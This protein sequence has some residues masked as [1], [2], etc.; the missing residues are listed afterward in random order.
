MI[1]HKDNTVLYILFFLLAV[2]ITTPYASASDSSC[3]SCHENVR[4]SLIDEDC[5][6]CHIDDVADGKHTD[7]IGH[8]QN[9]HEDF[10]WEND[11]EVESEVDRKSESCSVCHRSSNVGDFNVCEN[12]HL[13]DESDLFRGPSSGLITL[14]SG[15][16]ETIVRVYAHTNF[17]SIY[18]PDQ[19]DLGFTKSTC[20]GFSLITGEGTCHGVQYQ[21]KENAGGYFAHNMSNSGSIKR[22]N[23]YMETNTIDHLP[24]TSD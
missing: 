11:N 17:S 5:L 24:D 14:R 16:N 2:L 15:I 22:S 23:P 1:S 19:S 4:H 8:V 13:P 3:T 12:C 7:M 21:M 18:I 6:N 20:F 9:V 10:D